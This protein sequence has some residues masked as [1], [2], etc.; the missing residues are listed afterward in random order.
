VRPALQITVYPAG[1][2]HFRAMMS[3]RVLAVSPEPTQAAARVSRNERADPSTP[4]VMRRLGKGCMRSTVGAVAGAPK[5]RQLKPPA[6]Q[7]SRGSSS[8][9]QADPAPNRY[10]NTATITREPAAAA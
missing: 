8:R 3:D 6:A 5:A 9:G 7:S 2:D 10:Q 1:A 4:L